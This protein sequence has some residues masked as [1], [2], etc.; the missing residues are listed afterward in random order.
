MKNIIKKL[1]IELEKR[2]EKAKLLEQIKVVE[3]NTP[4]Q[5]EL[6]D[7][8]DKLIKDSNSLKEKYKKVNI[9]YYEEL[10]LLNN[11]KNDIEKIDIKNYNRIVAKRKQNMLT[12]IKLYQAVLANLWNKKYSYRKLFKNYEKKINA[13]IDI[14]KKNINDERFNKTKEGSKYSNISIK[15]KNK[16]EDLIKELQKHYITVKIKFRLDDLDKMSNKILK[17][18]SELTKVYDFLKILSNSYR[19]D[20][21]KNKKLKEII[22]QRKEKN[23]KTIDDIIF[24]IDKIKKTNNKDSNEKKL[25]ELK[26]NL[27]MLKI[28][29]C[30]NNILLN[31][32]IFNIK[33]KYLK[34]K[35][36]Y[37]AI[38]ANY[39]K[40]EQ[41][42]YYIKLSVGEESSI[43]MFT[44]NREKKFDKILL[45][46]SDK[47]TSKYLDLNV[48]KILEN[49]SINKYEKLFKL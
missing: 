37:N 36:I 11:L 48:E 14:F 39:E 4:I 17:E 32:L 5:K 41:T 18:R 2:K 15:L 33:K 10:P 19:E 31:D 23:L 13:F 22:S 12:S 43:Y 44:Q 42:K 16:G 46:K 49:F 7:M 35:T 20:N 47:F 3:K 21:T 1:E 34:G 27:K 8:C 45:I 24:I 29:D 40:L 30:Y 38:K 26:N 9:N 28:K 6:N 25:N